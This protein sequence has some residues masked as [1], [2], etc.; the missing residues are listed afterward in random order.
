[1]DIVKRIAFCALLVLAATFNFANAAQVPNGANMDLGTPDENAAKLAASGG[2]VAAQKLIRQFVIEWESGYLSKGMEDYFKAL[3]NYFQTNYN[4][5]FL[6]D[7]IN[8][9]ADP[10]PKLYT[11]LAKALNHITSEKEHATSSTVSATAGAVTVTQQVSTVFSHVWSVQTNA[12]NASP[13]PSSG[14]KIGGGA[15]SGGGG[16]GVVVVVWGMSP[17]MTWGTGV[18]SRA[19]LPGRRKGGSRLRTLSMTNSITSSVGRTTTVSSMDIPGHVVP[20]IS[21]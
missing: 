4:V 21:T 6:D 15:N 2:T 8:G 9:N 13:A 20:V 14:S 12:G 19:G 16:G 5:N 17:S 11:V 7:I 3:T 10:G 18:G 1:M